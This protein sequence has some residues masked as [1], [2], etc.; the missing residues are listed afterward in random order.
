MDSDAAKQFVFTIA[1]VVTDV[2]LSQ[3]GCGSHEDGLVTIDSGASVNVSSKWFG[4]SA[5]EE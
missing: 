4:E 3:S 1:S 5:L 2:S